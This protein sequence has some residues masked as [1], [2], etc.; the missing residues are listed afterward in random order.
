MASLQETLTSTQMKITSLSTEN[1]KL[2]KQLTEET[3]S[4]HKSLEILTSEATEAVKRAETCV[5]KEKKA[6]KI[7]EQQKALAAEVL[8]ILLVFFALRFAPLH[9]FTVLHV[10]SCACLIPRISF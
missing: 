2:K 5:E 10:H 3:A 9:V 6:N 7:C 8:C 4:L 1:T